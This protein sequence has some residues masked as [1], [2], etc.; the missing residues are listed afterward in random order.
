MAASYEE[1]K[2][3]KRMANQLRRDALTAL[4]HSGSGHPGGSLSAAEIMSVLYFREMKIR[5]EQPDWED[6]D[7]FVMSKG[8]AC[9][10]YYAA[11]ARRGYFDP[12]LLNTL[13]TPDSIL[14]GHPVM[15]KTPGVDMSTGSLGQ[16]L[17]AAAGMAL[18]AKKKKKDFHVYCLLGDGECQEGQ[19]WE[20]AMSAPHFGLNRLTALLDANHLQIDGTV[21]EVM[22]I[23]PMGD[24]LRAFGWNVLEVD[25][26]SVEQLLH[27]LELARYADRPTFILCRTIKGKGV[28]LMENKAEW[29]G[30]TVTKDVLEL[31]LDQLK[32]ED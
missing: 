4:Y 26:H 22:N 7:R 5:P 20:A 1:V 13:R 6:R 12:E 16:G 23:Y 17:S 19:I 11:L 30:K 3:L 25:G 28:S 29:H 24:K 32:Q 2:E 9:P 14:Q 27:A 15:G 18:Y 31:A 21:D 10:I 8:H